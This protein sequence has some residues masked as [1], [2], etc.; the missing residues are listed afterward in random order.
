LDGDRKLKYTDFLKK[1]KLL[2]GLTESLVSEFHTNTSEKMERVGGFNSNANKKTKVTKTIGFV[3]F[4]SNV[5]LEPSSQEEHK[6]R[7]IICDTHGT[8]STK[9]EGMARERVNFDDFDSLFKMGATY[10]EEYKAKIN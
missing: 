5:I 4:H 7:V 10:G 8:F 6:G 2:M 1:N 3:F 9:A